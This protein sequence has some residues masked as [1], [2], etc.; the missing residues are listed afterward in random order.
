[1]CVDTFWCAILRM[2]QFLFYKNVFSI[3]SWRNKQNGVKR[4]VCFLVACELTIKDDENILLF[5]INWFNCIIAYVI[6]NKGGKN[7]D[8]DQLPPNAPATGESNGEQSPA[9]GTAAPSAQEHVDQQS[10]G[11]LVH[12]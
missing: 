5:H 1:M 11:T 4:I 2:C 3:A 6:C 7:T 12:T 9:T 10:T 8:G